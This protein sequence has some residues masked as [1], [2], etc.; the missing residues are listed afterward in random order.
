MGQGQEAVDPGIAEPVAELRQGR[1]R[2]QELRARLHMEQEIKKFC[3]DVP[4]LAGGFAHPP[5]CREPRRSRFYR[6]EVAGEGI[7][8]DVR[9]VGLLA[10]FRQLGRRNEPGD[11]EPFPLLLLRALVKMAFE[12]VLEAPCFVFLGAA[13][14]EGAKVL[15][16][17]R[18]GLRVNLSFWT[19]SSF[20]CHRLLNQY[21]G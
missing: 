20:P 10:G 7:D 5:N 11:D 2:V 12:T 8:N 17:A 9:E 21:S 14:T 18:F 6:T 16:Q 13:Q 3:F 15:A 19:P 1:G 4:I